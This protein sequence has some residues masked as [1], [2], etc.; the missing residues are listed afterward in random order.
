[1]YIADTQEF[2]STTDLMNGCRLNLAL[3]VYE[4]CKTKN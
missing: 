1:M 2:Y 4:R 3:P